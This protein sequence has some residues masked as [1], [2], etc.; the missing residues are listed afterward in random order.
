ME[1][2]EPQKQENASRRSFLGKACA[3]AGTGLCA[4]GA[5]PVIRYLIPQPGFR[6]SGPQDVAASGDIP[7]GKSTTVV[8]PGLIVLII[9]SGGKLNAVNAKCTHLGCIVEWD[10]GADRIR[11]NCHGGLFTPEGNRLDVPPPKEQPPLQV[12]EKDGRIIVT[13]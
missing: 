2:G 5:V 1:S 9:R 6:L 8:F 7:E 4:F 3:A 11:C 10:E 13:L 12:E